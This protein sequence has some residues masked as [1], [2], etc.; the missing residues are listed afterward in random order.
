MN[1]QR[2]GRRADATHTP[3]QQL[4]WKQPQ[5]RLEPSRIVSGDQIQALHRQALK[6]LEVIGMDV[7]LP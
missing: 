6:V 1:V 3:I 2:R 4:S 7:L 5:H